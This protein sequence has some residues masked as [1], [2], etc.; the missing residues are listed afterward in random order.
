MTN[1]KVVVTGSNTLSRDRF[2]PAGRYS[3]DAFSACFDAPALSKREPLQIRLEAPR[4]GLH[5]MGTR[6]RFRVSFFADAAGLIW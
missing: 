1:S 4:C 5:G 3:L 6:G 2:D